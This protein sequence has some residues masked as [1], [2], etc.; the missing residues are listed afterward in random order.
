MIRKK[1]IRPTQK[2]TRANLYRNRKGIL[3]TRRNPVFGFMM[4]LF[5]LVKLTLTVSFG[6]TAIGAFSFA[7]IIG[8]H[9]L[10]NA[11]YF[12]V[13]EI[14]LKG[15]NRT[16]EPDVVRLT[17]L[18][19]PANIF[20]LRLGEMGE[21]LK[22][23]P[24]V[25]DVSLKRQMPETIIVEIV[26]HRPVALLDIGEI[27]YLNE[28]GKPFK[29]LGDG[30]E[31]GLPVVTGFT[32]LDLIRRPDLVQREMDTVLDLLNIL[33]ERNDRV[34]LENIASIKYD[35]IRGITLRTRE[36]NLQVEVG[37]KDYRVKFERLGRVLAHLKIKGLD[38]DLAY[39]N[40][41]CGPRVIIR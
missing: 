35:R 14:V 6:I 22:R 5:R 19:K 17:G 10:T 37:S 28:T 7:L 30:K 3:K 18:D 8:Y 27:Y 26:E 31:N 20:A 12:E 23:H 21:E 9:Q 36:G 13:K 4:G 25:K 1:K 40:L 24:W 39:I 34:R 29:K 15:L 11:A 32:R 41:E 33:A 16:L 2:S 38:R